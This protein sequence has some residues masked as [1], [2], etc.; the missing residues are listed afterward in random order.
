MFIAGPS[1][2]YLLVKTKTEELKVPRFPQ[3]PENDKEVID[4]IFANS[5]IRKK[6]NQEVQ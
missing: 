1:Y 4:S 3:F 2:E 5:E 6:Q